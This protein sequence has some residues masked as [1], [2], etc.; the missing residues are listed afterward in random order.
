MLPFTRAHPSTEDLS[1]FLD[2]ELPARRQEDVSR[3]VAACE[4]CATVVEDLGAAKAALGGLTPEHPSRSFRLGPEYALP[5]STRPAPVAPRPSPFAFA[6]AVALTLLVALLA[7]DFV[8]VPA[9]PTAREERSMA[10]FDASKDDS[11]AGALAPTSR[12][13]APGAAQS[14]MADAVAP[15]PAPASAPSLMPGAQAPTAV[16]PNIAAG[17]RAT[18]ATAIGEPATPDT[19]EVEEDGRDWLRAVEALVAL[20][21]I[22]SLVVVLWPRLMSGG[23]NR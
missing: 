8:I 19:V 17:E 21:F 16:P 22:G 12:E 11:G 9:E 20:V 3:H 7:V 1:A 6:P 2:G 5:P 10:T 23:A 4:T 15:T 13:A 18:G 14:Q